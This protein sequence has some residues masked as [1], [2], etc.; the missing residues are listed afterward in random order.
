[1]GKPTLD[2]I[3]ILKTLLDHEV[4]FIIVGGV[5]AVLHGSPISTFD[6]DLVHSRTPNNIRCP[7]HAGFIFNFG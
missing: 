5:S 2:F 6:L 4:D 1:M 7:D 3:K